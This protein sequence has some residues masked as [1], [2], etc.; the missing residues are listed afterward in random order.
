MPLTRLVQPRT[1]A[2]L[3]QER[4]VEQAR[5][6]VPAWILGQDGVFKSSNIPTFRAIDLPLTS[7]TPI[8]GPIFSGHTLLVYIA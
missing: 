5:E 8:L 2:A 6:R 4:L 3:A 1:T 7:D